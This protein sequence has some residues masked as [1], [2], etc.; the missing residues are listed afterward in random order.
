MSGHVFLIYMYIPLTLVS[1]CIVVHTHTHTHTLTHTH[2]HTHT[3]TQ[4]HNTHTHTASFITL[5]TRK[6]HFLS[7]LSPKTS[8][9]D[10]LPMNDQEREQTVQQS[11]LNLI[12]MRERRRDTPLFR[13][14]SEETL[15]T[16]DDP[17]P[18]EG[19]L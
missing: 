2:T 1:I 9:Q 14:Y 13:L 18:T 15:R 12:V 4:T 5:H 6:T 10:C 8:L 11:M 3:H 19:Q 16:I 17:S 7:V